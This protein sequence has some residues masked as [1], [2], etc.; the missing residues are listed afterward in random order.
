LIE[1]LGGID[2]WG[3]AHNAQKFVTYCQKN[4]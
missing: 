4:A 2:R 3:C 1:K